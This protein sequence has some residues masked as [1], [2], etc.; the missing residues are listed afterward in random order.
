MDDHVIARVVT[1]RREM[2]LRLPGNRDAF[3][4]RLQRLADYL[5]SLSDRDFRE[6]GQAVLDALGPARGDESSN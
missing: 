3:Q 4:A 6:V 1:G 2:V 5:A